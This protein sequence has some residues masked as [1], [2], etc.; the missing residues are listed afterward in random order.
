MMIEQVINYQIDEIVI[1]TF[2]DYNSLDLMNESLN[3]I[4]L[5]SDFNEN[6]M[7]KVINKILAPSNVYLNIAKEILSHPLLKCINILTNG[8]TN[9]TA[10][11]TASR[12]SEVL[13]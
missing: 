4:N 8:N 11:G 2:F 5:M 3:F 10:Q 12:C 6:F 13:N 9:P 7:D 1:D